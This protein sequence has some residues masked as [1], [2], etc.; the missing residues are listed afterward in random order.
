MTPPDCPHECPNRRP[1]KS[2]SVGGGY[3]FSLIVTL[4]LASQ[5]FQFSY[6]R[7]SGAED[8]S[9]SSQVP[10]VHVLVGC[11]ALIG[12]GLG[13]EIDKSSVTGAIAQAL[14]GQF[15]SLLKTS[16]DSTKD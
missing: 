6:Q 12:L 9:F 3:I 2:A 16:G 13:I 14:T 7:Q 5:C 1:A 10:P 11:L 4:F 15:A 8:L